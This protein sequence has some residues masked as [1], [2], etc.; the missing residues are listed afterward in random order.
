MSEM[1]FTERLYIK[2]LYFFGEFMT[3]EIE[4]QNTRACL[5]GLIA[6]V[7]PP[8]KSH[9]NP[10]VSTLIN[11]MFHFDVDKKQYEGCIRMMRHY[12]LMP[13]LLDCDAGI[14]DSDPCIYDV[15]SEWSNQK[16]DAD[17]AKTLQIIA[18]IVNLDRYSNMSKVADEV[19]NRRKDSE[20]MKI[21]MY[22]LK[23]ST[24]K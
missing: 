12:Q 9:M 20:I 3:K 18:G 7:A 19:W 8:G 2:V 21:V 10:H 11:M 14:D 16:V 6:I 1:S 5:K 22:V 23:S 17:N 24:R 13:P 15:L 4:D